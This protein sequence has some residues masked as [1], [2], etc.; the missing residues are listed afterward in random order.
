M[1]TDSENLELLRSLLD[2]IPSYLFVVDES[3]RIILYN[4]AAATL[5]GNARTLVLHQRTGDA[6]HCL[7]AEASMAKCGE[8]KACQSCLIRNAMLE[9]FQT[10]KMVRRRSK[11]V[12]AEDGKAKDLFMVVTA[13]PFTGLSQRLVLLDMEDISSVVEL[14]RLIPICAKCRK[15]RDDKDY[16]TRLDEYARD[17]LGADFTHG[18]CPDCLREEIEAVERRV[19]NG[20]K[21]PIS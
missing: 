15:V 9:A 21:P 14:Q 18:Y 20:K 1:N 13:S 10:G 19:K 2:A 3:L 8:T 12:L 6:L 17:H 11:L 5:V 7:N 16:W 4:A